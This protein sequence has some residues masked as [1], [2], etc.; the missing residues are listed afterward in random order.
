MG[1]QTG[2]LPSG[3]GGN[4]WCIIIRDQFA[5]PINAFVTCAPA[6]RGKR[7]QISENRKAN[8]QNML[9]YLYMRVLQWIFGLK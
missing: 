3:S 5:I 6:F 2:A 7:S 1:A 8:W 4:V 9:Q